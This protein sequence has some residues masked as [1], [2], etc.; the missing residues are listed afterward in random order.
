MNISFPE[1]RTDRFLLRRF[2]EDDLANV[3]KGLSHPD[4][5]RYY[6]VS[7][8]TMESTKAQMKFFSDLEE[9]GTGIWWAICSQDDKVFYGAGGL[10]SLKAEHR[11]A[12]IGYWLLPEF[13]GKGIVKEVLPA[14]CD[15]GFNDLR[16][17]RIEAVVETENE[18]SKKA[19]QSIGFHYEGTM[20][21]CEFKSGKF[22]SLDLFAK[23]SKV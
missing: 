9:S 1:L 21:E 2:R 10:N 18:R 20:K 4:V 8:S 19:I 12:E 16:L 23:L 15:Y 22:I 7:Y 13:W 11:K 5:I 6:G 17:H 14:I 3:Y